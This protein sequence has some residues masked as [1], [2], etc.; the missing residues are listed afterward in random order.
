MRAADIVGTWRVLTH[1]LLHK[2]GTVT[3][4]HGETHPAGIIYSAD[5]HMALVAT[6]A[7]RPKFT[8]PVSGRDI[9][10][11]TRDE[12][13]E[14]AGGT[15]AYFG[16]YEVKSDHDRVVH[17]IEVSLFLNWEGA[18]QERFAKLDDDRL[19]LSIAPD[20]DGAVGRVFWRRV[21]T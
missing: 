4:P 1:D 2:D 16:R 8:S 17:H 13:A 5:G 11:A 18:T 12:L 7:N 3:Y 15:V 21:R 10:G 19:T 9:S 14:A 6:R 20:A